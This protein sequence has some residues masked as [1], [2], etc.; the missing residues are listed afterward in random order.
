MSVLGDGFAK[1][2]K[3]IMDALE[4][5]IKTACIVVQADAVDLV[6]VDTGLLKN[7]IHNDTERKQSEVIGYVGTNTEYAPFQ[8]YGTVK[9]DAQPYLKPALNMNQE[10]IKQII[11]KSIG[12]AL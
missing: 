1:A 5:G 6:P 12:V 10:N 7:S 9:M 3:L 4:R 2:D 8:E 11:A